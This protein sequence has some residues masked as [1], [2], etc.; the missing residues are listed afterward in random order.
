[1]LCLT[2]MGNVCH[3]PKA[4]FPCR[5]QQLIPEMTPPPDTVFSSPSLTYSSSTSWKVLLLLQTLLSL[6]GSTKLTLSEYVQIKQMMDT[7]L[8][9]KNLGS[10]LAQQLSQSLWESHLNVLDIDTPINLICRDYK[11]ANLRELL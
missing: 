2:A 6:Q 11:G 10:F 5:L 3:F 7:Y 8:I 4:G 9:V 1:M